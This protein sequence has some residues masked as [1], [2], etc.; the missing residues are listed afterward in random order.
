MHVGFGRALVRGLLI[1]LVIPPL[2][3]DTDLRGLHDRLTNTAVVRR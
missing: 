3:T 1:A 2:F